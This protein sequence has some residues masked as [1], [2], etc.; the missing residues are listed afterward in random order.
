[1]KK[2]IVSYA[3]M[4]KDSHKHALDVIKEL[5]VVYRAG[6]PQ[7]LGECWIFYGCEN[8]PEQLPACVTVSDM[9][10]RDFID[11][12]IRQEVK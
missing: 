10:D 12:G 2:V 3:A 11:S 6:V 9:N 8:I 1:M 4:H 7:Y 5:N